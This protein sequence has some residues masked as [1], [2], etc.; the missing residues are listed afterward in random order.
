MKIKTLQEALNLIDF[1]Y[2]LENCETPDYFQVVVSI[3]GDKVTY[4]IYKSNGMVGGW[5]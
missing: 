4:R 3:G 1:D 2:I 5:Y